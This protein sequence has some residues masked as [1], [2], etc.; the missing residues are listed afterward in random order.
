MAVHVLLICNPNSTSQDAALYRRIVPPL[1]A[2]PGLSMEVRFTQRP[3]HAADMV[4]ELTRDDFDAVIAV[5]GDG[6]VNEV[7]NGML[8]PVPK[9]DET[10]ATNA[11]KVPALAVIPAGSANVF[12]RALGFAADPAEAAGQL[13][14]CLA[15]D[16][17][18]SIYLGTWDEEWFAVNAG[19]GL[20]ADVL[21]K[22]EKARER[23]FAATPWR[24]VGVAARAWVRARRK[25]P[26]ITV[27]A[28]AKGG[29]KLELD[30]VPVLLAS[31]TNPW[32]F[33]GSL[34]MVTNPGNSF[35]QGLGLFSL[36]EINGVAGIVGM[37]HLIGAD[38]Q[39]FLRK[40]VGEKTV[41][42]DDAVCVELE[43]PREH[44]FQA[45]GEYEGKR[46]KVTLRSVP[47]AIEVFAPTDDC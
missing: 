1:R 46:T 25:P 23:G 13:A 26:Q 43:C 39:G 30:D 4:S 36:T 17:R 5:G 21:A 38:S 7:V 24:Y 16:S 40:L 32:T 28:T 29:D 31:N 42:F 14:E 20:D 18:R 9:G 11:E 27:R 15:R 44:R 12:V 45:D 3:G 19:F 2:V 6:T 8:G 34:P 37:L 47:D 35:R 41:E 33:F 22:M 10:P